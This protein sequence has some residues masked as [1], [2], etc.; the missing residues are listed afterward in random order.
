MHSDGLRM[1]WKEQAWFVQE[2][3]EVWLPWGV[4]SLC[5]EGAQYVVG[6]SPEARARKASAPKHVSVNT[7]GWYSAELQAGRRGSWFPTWK[8]FES[9]WLEISL[10]LQILPCKRK[11]GW[12]FETEDCCCE[13]LVT[14][15]W[16]RSVF[17]VRFTLISG[18]GGGEMC[19]WNKSEL[20]QR[21][22][23][24]DLNGDFF[25]SF[26]Q[27]SW[28]LFRVQSLPAEDRQRTRAGCL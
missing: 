15:I 28:A 27:K 2:F 18:L 12:E 21:L 26:F 6:T 7:P 25:F 14:T 23:A 1:W 24:G 17:T 4:P 10:D 11:R 8:S 20:I 19:S 9:S 16:S 22:W 13:L 5:R 3:A